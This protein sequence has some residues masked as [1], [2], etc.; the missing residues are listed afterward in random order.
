MRTLRLVSRI[1]VLEKS[2]VQ[3]CH[4]EGEPEFLSTEQRACV[5][6]PLAN[7]NVICVPH[8]HKYPGTLLEIREAQWQA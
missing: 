6:P 3:D 4:E 2:D 8:Y 5:G 1:H 7:F